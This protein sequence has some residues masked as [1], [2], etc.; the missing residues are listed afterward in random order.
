MLAA[1]NLYQGGI[2]PRIQVGSF[3]EL[4]LKG[5]YTYHQALGTPSPQDNMCVTLLHTLSLVQL[6][7]LTTTTVLATRLQNANTDELSMEFV[8]QDLHVQ[9]TAE[10]IWA[11][12]NFQ[13]NYFGAYPLTTPR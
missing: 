12:I 10:G 13:D 3:A 4:V 7:S 1:C 5:S 2:S 6:P 8:V 11:L 9:A